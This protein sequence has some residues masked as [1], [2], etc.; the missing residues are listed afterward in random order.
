M[1]YLIQFAVAHEDF[2]LV[3]LDALCELSHIN[4]ASVYDLHVA[5]KCVERGCP[6]LVVDLPSDDVAKRL[7]ERGI[8]IKRVLEL[9]G[10]GDTHEM[11]IESVKAFPQERLE[12]HCSADC[13]WSLQVQ[14][15]GQKKSLEG[16]EVVRKAFSFLPMLGPVNLKT[17]DTALWVLEE[18]TARIDKLRGMPDKLYIGRQ[19]GKASRKLVGLRMLQDR[20][21]LGPTSMDNELS[22]IMANTAL[23]R[24]GALVFDPFVGTGSILV[25]SASFGAVCMGTDIDAVVMKGK[26]EGNIFSNFDQFGLPRPE[27]IVCDNSMFTRHFVDQ[28]AHDTFDAIVCDPP[29]GVRAGAKKCGSRKEVITPV[30]PEFRDTHIP[31]RKAYAVNDVMYDLLAVA[32]RCLK[33]GGRLVYLM[34]STY[35]TDPFEELPGHPLLQLIGHSVQGLTK[36]TCRRL[37][38][39][40]KIGPWDSNY[41]D[42]Y[43]ET[44][45]RGLQ[46]DQVSDRCSINRGKPSEEWLNLHRGRGK[47]GSTRLGS[48]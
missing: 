38:T 6:F 16:Q 47:G 41:E 3:E 15:V 33:V 30:R 23:A 39:M 43:A 46:I 22:L 31:Q 40:R 48:N 45:K 9:W 5:R 20:A 28:W 27:V 44:A 14:G 18:Y 21:Y 34:P 8:L 35:V 2:R 24:P 11:L 29:Y 12:P 10:E 7:I 13:S 37:I 42:E 32:A 26:G 19:V 36:H 1:R 4:P 17:P 25:S